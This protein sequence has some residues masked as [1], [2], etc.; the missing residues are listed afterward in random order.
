MN[1]N[2]TVQM[3]PVIFFGMSQTTQ[4][5][6]PKIELLVIFSSSIWSFRCLII[7]VWSYPEFL[8][9]SSLTIQQRHCYC[10]QLLQKCSVSPPLSYMLCTNRY[11]LPSYFNWFLT[12]GST[13]VLGP[14]YASATW[15]RVVLLHCKIML[16]VYLEL[17]TRILSNPRKKLINNHNP[18]KLH[19][20]LGQHHPLTS[21]PTSAPSIYHAYPRDILLLLLTPLPTS[22][23]KCAFSF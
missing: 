21:P 22:H 8:L 19:R 7:P 1:S 2:S 17:F 23:Q 11:H 12:V 14:C 13:S 4:I 9:P 18:R 6:K 3:P 16:F 5:T 20:I 10:L 15:L